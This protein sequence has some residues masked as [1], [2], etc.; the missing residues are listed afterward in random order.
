[1]KYVVGVDTGGTFTDLIAVDEV[2][3]YL[4]VKTPSTPS[5][6]SLAVIEGLR[7]AGEKI[8]KD[9]P[10]FLEDVTRICHGT[11]VSTN[12]VLTWTGAKVGLLCTEGFRDTLEIRFGIREDPYDYTIPAPKPLAPR[13]LRVPV[14]ERIK[15]DGSEL[16]PLNEQQVRDACKYL[17]GQGVQSVVVGFVWSFKNRAHEQRAVEICREEMPDVYVIGSCDIQSEIREYWRISTAVLSAYVGPALSHYLKHM[18]QT[19]G[20]NGFKGQLLITQSN[21]G[22]MF[23]EIAEEQAARTLLSG[24][25]C[26]PAAAAYIAS[27]LNMK[28][29][30]TCDM[31]GT[32]FDVALIKNEKP[33]TALEG[34]VGGVYHLRLPMVDVHT[35]GAGGGSIGWL[36]AM[37]VLHMGPASAGADPGPACYGKGG[38]EPT[39]T[40]ADLVL[41]YLDPEY[42]LGGEMSVDLAL[43]ENAIKEKIADPLG[44][45]V[46][47]AAKAMRKIVDHGMSDAISEVSVQRGEDPRRYALVAA[48][49]AGPVHIASLAQVL[50]IKKILIP[51]SSSIF[52]AIG[53]IIAD[54]RHD[55]VTSVVAKTNEADLDL[56][57]GV[58]G[59]MKAVGD[60]YLGREGIEEKDRYYSK[61][62]DMR[63]LGQF[64]EVE[65]PISEAELNQ[66]EVAQIVRDFHKK[67]EELYAYSEPE[68]ATEMINLRMA[69]FGKV[70][71]PARKTH[72]GG[73]VMDASRHIKGKRDVYFE[74]KFG[75]VPTFIYVGD[76][77]EVGN[78]VEGPAIIEQSTT[79]IVVPPGARLDVTEYG[80][81]LMTLA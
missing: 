53:S 13:Y 10:G 72:S 20:D 49:G 63:Y 45:T 3:D 25:A 67:H 75:F 5:D 41:G 57:N 2:G 54:L 78:I 18:V 31:G 74:E 16:K 24:P 71:P 77:M 66:D 64:H 46:V 61:S 37:N 14:E 30:I 19:L 68:S 15:W 28:D 52:C 69:T 32:S 7:R 56:L 29:L 80:D 26:A 4:I 22:V 59:D 1:M 55:L 39:S 17:L 76:D 11:T 12:T 73:A 44:L 35:I 23:P 6:P 42:F 36:D 9:L 43:A 48:G 40:D 34:A 62:V 50:N 8:G 38:T 21:A 79:T 58:F 47:E 27:P 33:S 65:L 51:R 70:V 81:Y 60:G